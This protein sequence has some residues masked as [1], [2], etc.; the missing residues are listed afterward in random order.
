MGVVNG[1][2]WI[3]IASINW[4]HGCMVFVQYTTVLGVI[5]T[6]T[7][8]GISRTKFMKKWNFWSK[9]GTLQKF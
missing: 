9:I 6:V 2:R 8:I 4:G 1:W 7:L 5:V 3:Y